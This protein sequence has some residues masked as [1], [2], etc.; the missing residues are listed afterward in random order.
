MFVWRSKIRSAKAE[1]ATSPCLNLFVSSL[2]DEVAAVPQAHDLISVRSFLGLFIIN[3][4]IS[5]ITKGKYYPFLTV[6][7]YPYESNLTIAAVKRPMR[8][9]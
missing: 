3:T 1:L 2:F 6:Q 8:T 4:T 5:R 9:S 7:H